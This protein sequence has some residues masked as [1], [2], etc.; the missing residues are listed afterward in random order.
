MDSVTHFEVP[1]DDIERAKKFY[2]ETFGWRFDSTPG[3]PYWM[4]YTCEVDEKFMAK[5]TNKINGG[6]Y[7]RSDGGSPNPSIVLS[8]EDIDASIEKIKANGGEITMEK[9]QVG[10]MGL[11]VQAKDTEGNIFGVWQSLQ[12]EPPQ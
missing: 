7:K 4:A 12:K 5:E 11:Y 10:D 3:M 6:F 9:R 1:V 2:A 8:T